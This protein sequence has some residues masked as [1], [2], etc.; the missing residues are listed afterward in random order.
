MTVKE[1]KIQY[2]LG[3]LSN[4]MKEDFA[5]NKN[6]PKKILAVLSKDEYWGTRYAVAL[7]ESTPIKTLEILSED[8]DKWVRSSVA[9]N[10]NTPVEILEVLSKDED[11]LIKSY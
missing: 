5:S 3:A 6:T 4:E 7:N 8:K 11:Y 10:N 2:A 9:K 1:F